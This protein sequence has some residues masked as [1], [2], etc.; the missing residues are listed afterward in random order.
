ME[1]S[2]LEGDEEETFL[3]KALEDMKKARER[4]HQK[5]RGGRG[6]KF[7]RNDRK[8]RNDEREGGDAPSKQAKTDDTNAAVPVVTVD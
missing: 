8:R 1:L 6:G 4:I 3:K 2:L 7:N 5:N